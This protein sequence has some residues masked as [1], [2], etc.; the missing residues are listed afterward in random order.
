MKRENEELRKNRNKKGEERER[1][2][3]SRDK[4]G[5]FQ[6]ACQRVTILPSLYKLRHAQH[7]H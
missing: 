2:A 3:K 4:E 7:L 6:Q 5:D 1:R